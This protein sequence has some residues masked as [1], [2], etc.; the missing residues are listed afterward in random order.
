MSA[1]IY[2]LDTSI[3]LPIARGGPIAE[4]LDR[5]FGLRAPGPTPLV[6]VVS[7]GEL[8][9]IADRNGWG[10]K[11]LAEI[12]RLFEA[13]VVIDIGSPEVMSSYVALSRAAHRAPK[14]ARQLSNNDLWIASCAAATNA[15]LLTAD[16]DFD[17]FPP[18]LV[19]VQRI[20]RPS[21]GSA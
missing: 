2:L 12:D 4:R 9:V 14:G 10:P 15:T 19:A 6:S 18:A 3:L 20:S 7:E 16:E 1:R 5:S 13:L 17:V 8:R 21:S 11:K